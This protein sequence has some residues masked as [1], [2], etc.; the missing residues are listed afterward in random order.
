MKSV[1]VG[2]RRVDPGDWQ[3]GRVLADQTDRAQWG[4]NVVGRPSA[5]F[6]RAFPGVMGLS[7]GT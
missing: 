5:D 7:P 3:A 1:R 6:R 2:E 4:D